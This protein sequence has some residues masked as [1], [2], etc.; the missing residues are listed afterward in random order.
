MCHTKVL[1]NNRNGFVTRCA[2]CSK[3]QIAF[4]TSLFSMSLR[5]FEVFANYLYAKRNEAEEYGLHEKCIHLRNGAAM[6]I[7]TPYELENF[8]DL[9]E[10]ASIQNLIHDCL[11]RPN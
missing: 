10:T 3:V 1:V 7:L 6:M 5:D 4:G 2:E 8:I 11:N 9:I